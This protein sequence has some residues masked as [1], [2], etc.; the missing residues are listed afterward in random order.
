MRIAQYSSIPLTL[1]ALLPAAC[2]VEPLDDGDSRSDGLYDPAPEILANERTCTK[3]F[4]C[5]PI[6][7]NAHRSSP[8]EAAIVER[9]GA[10]INQ[11]D[12]LVG[13][14]FAQELSSVAPALDGGHHQL[15]VG[16]SGLGMITAHPTR[17]RGAH[18]VY[19][20][21]FVLWAGQSYEDWLGYPTS[22]EHDASGK[23]AA[24][25]AVRE[26]EF[27]VRPT[28][29]PEVYRR[30]LCWAPG[31]IWLAETRELQITVEVQVED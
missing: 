8:S 22:D 11:D 4:P 2:A 1:A 13:A 16:Q 6:Q 25:G 9:W 31:R 15:F 21:I 20:E 3:A 30:T 14:Y 28:G 18:L 24:D 7:P 5:V 19:G 12:G 10:L 17:S 23:C 27:E 29:G 26:Q